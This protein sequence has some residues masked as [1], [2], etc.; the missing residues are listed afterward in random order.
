MARG[1]QSF[2]VGGDY[3]S[4][5]AQARGA[6]A[7]YQVNGLNQLVDDRAALFDMAMYDRIEVL[8]GPAGL[9]KGAGSAGATINLVRRAPTAEPHFRGALTGGAG[10]D[11]APAPGARDRLPGRDGGVLSHPPRAG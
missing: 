10:P 6:T 4:F 3:T 2:S 5:N 9:F 1:V 7:D 11:P 8:R